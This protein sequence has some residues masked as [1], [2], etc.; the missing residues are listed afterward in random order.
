MT[1]N[2]VK[3]RPVTQQQVKGAQSI[4]EAALLRRLPEERLDVRSKQK[5]AITIDK[6]LKFPLVEEGL[7]A[8]KR[9]TRQNMVGGPIIKEIA[10]LVFEKTTF[11]KDFQSEIE[12]QLKRKH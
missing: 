2:V 7:A 1:A 12:N 4:A 3:E 11:E 8:E 10:N 5:S 6:S 9:I